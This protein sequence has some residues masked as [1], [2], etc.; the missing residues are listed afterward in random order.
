MIQL[1]KLGIPSRFVAECLILS[2]AKRGLG[3]DY[4]PAS[5]DPEHVAVRV[6]VASLLRTR[7]G[8]I[9]DPS[10]AEV[11]EVT[12][13]ACV[14][15]AKYKVMGT[16]RVLCGKG[17]GSGWR[18]AYKIADGAR[19]AALLPAMSI[20]GPVK[21]IAESNLLSCLAIAYPIRN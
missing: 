11:G 9:V 2:I 7:A 20:D 10:S 13:K 18:K 4:I 21:E 16:S 15:L 12:A 6:D 8:I 14:K 19:L 17:F 1:T 5:S 3:F